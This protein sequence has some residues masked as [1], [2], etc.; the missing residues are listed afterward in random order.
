MTRTSSA[1]RSIIDSDDIVPAEEVLGLLLEVW[2]C[3]TDFRTIVSRSSFSCLR[4]F[5]RVEPVAGVPSASGFCSSYPGEHFMSPRKQLSHRR[6][7][8][9]GS[10]RSIQGTRCP[11]HSM[12]FVLRSSHSPLRSSRMSISHAPT[13]RYGSGM[14]ASSRFCELLRKGL[15]SIGGACWGMLVLWVMP[16]S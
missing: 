1:V 14:E 4:F 3:L 15:A 8:V 6:R 10:T 16:R 11:V 13:R 5:V 2:A 7:F 12:H 9:P